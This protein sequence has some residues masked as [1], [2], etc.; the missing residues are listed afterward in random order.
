MKTVSNTNS[1][2]HEKDIDSSTPTKH[3]IEIE[4]TDIKFVCDLIDFLVKHKVAPD[5]TIVRFKQ[6]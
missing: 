4:S 6:S 3:K 5:S 1:F 2:F